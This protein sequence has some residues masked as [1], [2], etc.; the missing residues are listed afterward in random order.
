[1]EIDKEIQKIIDDYVQKVI[2]N[3]E[4]LFKLKND[5]DQIINNSEEELMKMED[6]IDQKFNKNLINEEEYLRVFRENKE[7]ILQ[8]TKEKLEDLVKSLVY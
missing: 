7:I 2:D 6:S 8:K 5:I 3:E 1:M 4:S